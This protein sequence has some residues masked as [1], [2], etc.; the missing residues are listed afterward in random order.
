MTF[1]QCK[2]IKVS[3]TKNLIDL[4]V[5]FFTNK[6]PR[7]LEGYIERLKT[8]VNQ[9]SIKPTVRQWEMSDIKLG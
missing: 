2:Y 3:G 7:V 8:A 5:A 4:N 6:G 9:G 1:L